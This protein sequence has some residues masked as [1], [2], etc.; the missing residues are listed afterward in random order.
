MRLLCQRFDRSRPP[1]KQI[2]NSK[3]RNNP[4][5]LCYPGTAENLLEKFHVRFVPCHW[6]FLHF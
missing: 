2:R 3:L 5:T 6:E 4:N 1:G